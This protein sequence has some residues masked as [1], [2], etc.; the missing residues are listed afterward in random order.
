MAAE[1]HAAHE[2]QCQRNHTRQSEAPSQ[3]VDE[4]LG[5]GPVREHEQTAGVA[6]GDAG[7]EREHA[8]DVL[9]VGHGEHVGLHAG[10]RHRGQHQGGVVPPA[11]C[12]ARGHNLTRDNERHLAPRQARQVTGNVV[13][14]PIPGR[15]R[16]QDLL[17]ESH[18]HRHDE[19]QLALVLYEGTRRMPSDRG[20]LRVAHDVHACTRRVDP[21]RT[22][23]PC[24]VRP[25]HD[26]EGRLHLCA[27]GGRDGV[28]RGTV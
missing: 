11:L 23:Q 17:P 6:A 18:G 2:R 24:A 12:Q 25:G 20:V 3:R 7:L 19:E 4:L 13:G 14:Q 1:E 8:G 9:P 16:P 10:R 27:L 22:A 26:R 28:E 5:G 21:S 15:Q